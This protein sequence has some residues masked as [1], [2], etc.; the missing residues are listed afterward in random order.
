[1]LPLLA[2]AGTSIN[3]TAG[4][5]L[6]GNSD[7]LAI[8]V[9]GRLGDK[10][11]I[12]TVWKWNKQASRWSF[13]TPSMTPA[14]LSAYA[15]SKGYDVLASV[16]PKEGFWVNASAAAVVTADPLAA[17]PLPGSSVSSLLVND[18]TDGW[19]LVASA[20]NKNP[21]QLNAGL[22]GS[23]E[24]L[25]K[26]MVTVWGWD[27]ATS[28]WKFHAPSLEAQG[29]DVL[30]SYSQSKGYRS[31]AIAPASTDGFWVNVGAVTPSTTQPVPALTAAKA[32]VSTLRSNA[33]AL[34]AT[35]LSLQTELQAVS[36]DLKVRM[37]PMATSNVKALNLVQL[38]VQFWEDVVK[39]PTAPF[40]ASKTFYNFVTPWYQEPIGSCGFYASSTSSDLAVSKS[41][42]KI[43]GCATASNT[44][45]GTY[46][47]SA[48]VNGAPKSCSVTG[49]WCGTNWSTRI[50]LVADSLDANKFMVYTQTRESKTYVT[51][52]GFSYFD[53][54]QGIYVAGLASC[55]VGQACLSGAMQLPTIAIHY[56]AAFPG[57]AATLTLTRDAVSKIASLNLTGELSPG[58]NIQTNPTYGFNSMT[59]MWESKLNQTAT[60]LGDK[61]NVALSA[62][63]THL[64]GLDRLDLSG[65]VDLIKG[66]MLD[67]RLELAPGSYM[68]ARPD[69]TGSNYGANDGSQEMLLKLTGG[70]SISSLAGDLKMG[71]FKL[72]ASGMN[73][74]PTV[75]SFAGSVKRN[76]VSFFDGAITTE[77]LNYPTFNANMPVSG[78]NPQ[79][80][81]VGFSGNVMIPNRPVLK[82][83]FAATA[84]ST[85]G[86]ADVSQVSGQ[87]VQGPSIVNVSGFSSGPTNVQVLESSNGIK[88]VMD[89]SKLFYPLTKN[90]ILVGEFSTLNNVLTYTDNTYE[91]F[92]GTPG[93]VTTGVAV[94]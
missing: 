49:D 30:A 58:F 25:G 29:A 87:F 59:M 90:G 67:T 75:M 84:K 41:D 20:D 6:V 65:S 50:R 22:S 88:L 32:F 66:G 57:N 4:W 47:F 11:K 42:V 7:T 82:V 64:T 83:I 54:V 5:N 14:E 56:G 33:M 94:D 55:P 69:A 26:S 2:L 92:F 60:V 17:P 53:R 62:A 27:A 70:S 37:G 44:A 46:V 77:I 15:A 73:Y 23:L 9:P 45:N 28:S 10:T 8:D 76:G 86:M 80:A 71:A 68:Q 1:M 34:D 35:D 3:L 61:H 36:N 24:A 79:T 51:A 40:V 31:F 85:G 18:L 38:G 48:D 74:A 63:S 52:P 89:K 91:Q 72:D 12:T 39:N 78:W 43:V 19:N 13:F 81:R 21:S 93:T 16:A